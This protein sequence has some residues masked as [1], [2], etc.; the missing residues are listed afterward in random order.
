MNM[1]PRALSHVE[2]ASGYRVGSSGV[3]K[4]AVDMVTVKSTRGIES[5]LKMEDV[6]S[7]GTM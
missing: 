5:N 4:T 2:G 3:G 1:W 6:L 7:L